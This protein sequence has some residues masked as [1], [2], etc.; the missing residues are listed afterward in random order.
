LPISFLIT[1]IEGMCNGYS[2][3]LYCN[4]V[5]PFLLL[6]AS[7]LLLPL[8]LGLFLICKAAVREAVLEVRKQGLEKTTAVAS[9]ALSISLSF[10]VSF[11]V[12][13]CWY[14]KELNLLWLLIPIALT[15]A[16]IV[17]LL[18]AQPQK[19]G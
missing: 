17:S 5:R 9:P 19:H 15:T 4:N 18:R 3:D 1:A 7:P 14:Y 10:S 11:A 2:Y 6:I 8:A 13:H 16:L 12:T